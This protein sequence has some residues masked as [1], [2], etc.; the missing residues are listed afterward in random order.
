MLF[1]HQQQGVFF[2]FFLSDKLEPFIIVTALHPTHGKLGRLTAAHVEG[3]RVALHA[4]KE[5]H[6]IHDE[7]YHYTPLTERE[8]TEAFHRGGGAAAHNKAHSAHFHLK[9]R[10]ATAMYRLR[11]PVL[12][13][14]DFDRLRAAC[15]PVRYNYARETVPLARVMA[16]IEADALG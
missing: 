10:V 11:F 4:F 13:L 9:M 6:G 3:L 15:E 12:G 14:F 2:C 5:R 7:T 8:Q 1:H 16:A